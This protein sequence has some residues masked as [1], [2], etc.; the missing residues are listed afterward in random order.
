MNGILLALLLSGADGPGCGSVGTEGLDADAAIAVT[1][2]IEQYRAGGASPQAAGML[3]MVLHANGLHTAAL[4]CYREA[5][6]GE[7]GDARWAYLAGVAA[8]AEG[9]LE[10][11]AGAYWATLRAQPEYAPA[12]VRLATL[13]REAGAVADAGRVLVRFDREDASPAVQA[14]LG[15]QALAAGEHERAETL[16]RAALAARPEA[17]RLYYLLARS[18]Q[19][20]G[21]ETD[22]RA[23]LERR[24]AVG[25]MP[26]DPMLAEIDAYQAGAIAALLV[27]RRAFQAGQY[28]QARA[29]FAEALQR[30]P[31]NIS[32]RVNL[33]TTLGALEQWSEARSL[34]EE[35][36]S[37]DPDN[38][39]SLFN[40]A[41]LN[42]MDAPE[43]ALAYYRRL[44]GLE[45]T[46]S[47][48][49]YRLGVTLARLGRREAAIDALESA[50]ADLDYYAPATLAIVRQ[51]L[52]G[53]QEARAEAE[54]E[55]AR[56]VAP[57]DPSLAA[58]LISVWTT[59]RDPEVR[60]GRSALALAESRFEALGDSDSARL[61]AQ[62]HAELNQCAAASDWLSQAAALAQAEEV[63]QQL[64]AASQSMNSPCRAPIDADPEAG[65]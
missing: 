18:L 55:Q 38:R 50:R 42:E 30:D 5:G 36:L 19:A 25:L 57:R 61:V 27:G 17:D 45:P 31:D 41:A 13:L 51:L 62:A 20:Q 39:A 28:E 4:E 15:E 6:L 35:T 58:M 33:A 37:V 44:S 65:S 43:Q 3:G 64:R 32:A 9:R 14:A 56:G 2:G 48:V 54:L 59:A 23:A 8:Q 10:D 7:P 60:D 53:G 49:H 46:D 11:A 22:A 21:K 12:A 47:E 34:F 40:L 52:A 16:L 63:R 29:A 1:D 26:N 24:G